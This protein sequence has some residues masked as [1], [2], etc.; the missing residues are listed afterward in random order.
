[1]ITSDKV[2]QENSYID[3]LDAEV[4]SC[5][6]KEDYYEVILDKTI[7]YPH[8]SGGQPKDEG[9]I[10]GIKVFNVRE[11]EE[12]I[13]HFLKE[14][15]SGTVSVVIDF[16]IRFDYMQQHTGQHILS[17]VFAE[18]FN[19]N[20]V[21][22]HLSDNYTTVDI[23]IP[24]T[25]EM[26][27][28]AEI[29]SNK[30]I[31]DNKKV[32]AKTYAYEDA[33]KLHLRKA[34]IELDYLRIISIEQYDD[35]AC[36]G[37]HVNYTGEIGIL[38]VTKFE[39]YKNGTR[40]EFLCGN[41]ALNDYIAKNKNILS[42]ASSLTC[43]TDMLLDNF[44]KILNE[45]KKLKKDLN[46]LNGQLN[47]YKAKEFKQKAVFKDGIS[48]VFVYSDNDVKDLRFICSKITEDDNCVVVLSSEVDNVCSLIIG[49]SKNLILDIKNIFE[50]CKTLINGKGG[51]NNFLLQ[52]SGD[53]LKGKECLELASDIL[54][55]V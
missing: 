39:K 50:Q 42:L 31:Y 12:E 15:V 35:C 36:G 24:L 4:I 38:K 17:Y 14:P 40:V 44:E 22:F 21:G 27:E 9:T 45:N 20:T 25:D 41:R 32:T 13:I 16:S 48:Y 47:D 8:M 23:D 30:I 49:Q 46:I 2:Y 52:C 19:G 43:R 1:M 7:F 5:T 3:K 6:K 34:P 53:L 37:T 11:R 29:L 54:L 51:G 33:L 18:L 28:H 10:D 26:I 55:N